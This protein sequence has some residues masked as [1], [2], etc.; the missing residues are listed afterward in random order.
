MKSKFC[1]TLLCTSIFWTTNVLGE[2]CPNF[3]A[4][5]FYKQIQG[6]LSREG[7]IIIASDDGQ[8]W[9]I[10]NWSELGKAHLFNNVSRITPATTEVSPEGKCDYT[11]QLKGGGSVPLIVKKFATRPINPGQIEPLQPI[12]P[13]Q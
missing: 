11:I 10:E 1:L 5:G 13:A 3:N 7:V 2:N 12:T 6:V 8:G 9:A 4:E